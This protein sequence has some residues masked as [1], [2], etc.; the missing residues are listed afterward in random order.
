VYSAPDDRRE[1]RLHLRDRQSAQAVVRAEL[2]DDDGRPGLRER[3][4]DARRAACR[5]FAADA[6]IDHGIILVSLFQPLAEQGHP[7]RVAGNAVGGG[8]AVPEHQ[9]R[10]CGERRSAASEQDGKQ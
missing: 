1:V 4:G 10:R 5:S 6:R 2:E 8:Q 9:D 7:A 3:L